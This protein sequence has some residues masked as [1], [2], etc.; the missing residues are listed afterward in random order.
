M[1]RILAVLSLVFMAAACYKSG[2]GTHDTQSDPVPDTTPD[3]QPDVPVDM[4]VDMPMDMP[5]D[6]PLEPDV[7]PP[8]YSVTFV[9]ENAS[10]PMCSSCVYYLEYMDYSTIY[11]LGITWNGGN[12]I[13]ETPYCMMGCEDVTDPAYCCLPCPA[14]MPAVQQIVPGQR[15][16]VTWYGEIYRID[17]ERCD[18]GCYWHSPAA[19]GSGTVRVCAYRSYECWDSTCFMDDNGFIQ[20]AEGAGDT[21]CAEASFS[22]PADDGREVVLG[23][24][25]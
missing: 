4:P 20:M 8:P 17:S 22:F 10:P 1:T 6:V 5:T 12:I 3:Q 21:V 16:T 25:P 18:C 15:V 14:P 13:W 9:I 24:T 2:A 11:D 23:L 19:A 7:P